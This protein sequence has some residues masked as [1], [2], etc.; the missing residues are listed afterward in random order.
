MTNS[1]T[2]R[3]FI[4]LFMIP[5]VIAL[6]FLL[7]YT[8]NFEAEVNT[9]KRGT[10]VI[11]EYRSI[12]FLKGKYLAEIY[13]EQ[14][15]YIR[16]NIIKSRDF[17]KPYEIGQEVTI[18]YLQDGV[19]II[20]HL[21][22]AVFTLFKV[23]VAGFILLILL[24]VLPIAAIKANYVGGIIM[25]L[26]GFLLCIVTWF[27][28]QQQE[29]FEEHSGIVKAQVIDYI[30]DICED[31]DDDEYTCYARKIKYEVDGNPYTYVENVKRSSKKGNINDILDFYYLIDNP[32]EGQLTSI[33]AAK[34]FSF[35]GIAI[36]S[37]L[38]FG[39]YRIFQSG[40]E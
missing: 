4:I 14:G 9:A 31:S 39:G 6:S 7:Y 12:K 20:D 40:G 25:M 30:V 8:T 34:Y 28:Y 32:K 16:N 1:K 29:V 15:N 36:G 35:I 22:P 37:L 38:L 19:E 26:F 24:G 5:W 10:A 33:K 21:T 27:H 23:F 2:P 17:K 3:I 13:D 18:G 11:K